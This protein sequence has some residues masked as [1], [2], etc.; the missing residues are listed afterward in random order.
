MKKIPYKK[1]KRGYPQND[2]HS[3]NKTASSLKIYSSKKQKFKT[4]ASKGLPVNFVSVLLKKHR[5][6]GETHSHVIMET[7]DD[8]HVSVGITKQSTKGKKSNSRNYTCE[9]DILG[10]GIV[11]R[12]RRQGVVDDTNNYFHP[13]SSK[14]SEKDYRQAKIYADRAKAKYLKKQKK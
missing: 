3:I 12:L 9:T 8:K 6:Y 10:T 5:D 4:F 13:S 1:K 14:M 2:K 7:F 11:S